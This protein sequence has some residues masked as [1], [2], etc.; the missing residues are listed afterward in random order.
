MA[1][2]IERLA[3]AGILVRPCGMFPGLT[4]GHV[5]LCVRTEA[6]N[7]RLLAALKAALRRPPIPLEK[8]ASR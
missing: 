7:T 3:A 8:E 1:P 2:A 4:R 5:R 6:Q